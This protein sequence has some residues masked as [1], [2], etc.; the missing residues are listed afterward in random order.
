MNMSPSKMFKTPL[1]K[2]MELLARKNIGEYSDTED[3][4]EES[5]Y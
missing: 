5:K 4:D 2:A 3:S 1:H